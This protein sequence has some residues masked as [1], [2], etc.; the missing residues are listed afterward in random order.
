MKKKVLITGGAGYIGSY[1]N[2]LL[3][4][5][6]VETVVLDNLVS[7]TKNAVTR[8]R[9]IHGDM[10]NAPLLQQLFEAESFNAVMHFAA[11]LDVGE[12]VKQP[13]KYYKN[14]VA[15]T[16]NLLQ[17]M[18]EH[19]IEN[20]IFSSTAAIYGI[21]KTAAVSE[22]DPLN[23]INP[24]GESKLMVEKI[25]KSYSESYPFRYISLRYFNA[26]GGDPTGEVKPSLKSSHNLIPKALRS[27]IEN[28][29]VTIFGTDYPTADGTCIRDYI[30][31]HDLATAHV[32]AL[33]K[34]LQNGSSSVYNLGNGRGF[35][36]KEV[37]S[38][39]EKVTGRKL[40]INEGPRRDG[41]PPILIANAEKAAKE[42]QW[43]PIY[44]DLQKIVEDAWRSFS[45]SGR[46]SV[47]NQ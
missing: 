15:G 20:F 16:L 46:L 18:R 1:V 22:N 34:L 42:L 28:K 5:Q 4:E 13:E 41:D 26:A 39:I 3:N 40:L 12:S 24:Y 6:G 35:S 9:F 17:S 29:P 43:R 44:G 7:G 21:P 32:L 30:H 19:A 8:G 36:V 31:L 27:L 47:I 25:L 45:D 33:Q 14:N 11:F 37:L 23:P 2:K 10:S 38:T